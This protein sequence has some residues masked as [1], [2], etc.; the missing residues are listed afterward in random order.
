MDCYTCTRKAQM[1]QSQGRTIKKY[2]YLG[3]LTSMFYE[4]KFIE[5]FEL[6]LSFKGTNKYLY[7]T[8]SIY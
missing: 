4:T 8:T 6:F 3:E 7:C 2:I 1:W 5:Q